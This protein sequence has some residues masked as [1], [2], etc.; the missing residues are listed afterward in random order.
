MVATVFHTCS[1]RQHASSTFPLSTSNTCQRALPHPLCVTCT[2]QTS[3][4]DLPQLHISQLPMQLVL[5]TG[6]IPGQTAA[7]CM[8]R[9]AGCTTAPSST[10]RLPTTTSCILC[11]TQAGQICL[12]TMGSMQ[13][14]SAWPGPLTGTPWKQVTCTKPYI[15]TPAAAH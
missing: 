14:S 12:G 9:P 6:C 1:A 7:L 2:S 8:L 3:S 5:L 15:S 10:G 11:P 13:P 4:T